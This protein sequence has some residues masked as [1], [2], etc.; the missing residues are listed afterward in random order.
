MMKVAA[1]QHIDKL[2]TESADERKRVR[3]LV[4]SGA[5]VTPSLTLIRRSRSCRAASSAVWLPAAGA[6]AIVGS[7]IDYQPVSFS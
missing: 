1:E 5:G 3:R 6:E 7:T 4:A 2:I